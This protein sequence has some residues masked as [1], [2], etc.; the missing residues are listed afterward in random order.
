VREGNHHI[1]PPQRLLVPSGGDVMIQT[2]RVAGGTSTGW[3]RHVPALAILTKGRGEAYAA[4]DSGCAKVEENKAG[5]VVSHAHHTE[6]LTLF[7][8]DSEM[9]LVYWGMGNNRLPQPGLVNFA[10]AMDFTV[11]P[12]AGCTTI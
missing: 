8:E 1:A 7:T 6:H 9:V 5:D 2:A 3:Y 11:M 10:E 12:P 4:T